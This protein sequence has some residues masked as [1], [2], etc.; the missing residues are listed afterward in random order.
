MTK[1]ED[2]QPVDE[3]EEIL[4]GYADGEAYAHQDNK[5]GLT[6]EEAKARLLQW[7]IEQYKK[8]YIDGGIA[9]IRI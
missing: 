3:L 6:L 9:E 2:Q 4:E 8:G 7:G 5:I 1:L